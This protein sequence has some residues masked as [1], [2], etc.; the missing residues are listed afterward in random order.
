MLNMNG[1][2]EYEVKSEDRTRF[3]DLESIPFFHH[4][5]KIQNLVK[6]F[7]WGN[8]E[9]EVGSVVL[10]FSRLDG[11]FNVKSNWLPTQRNVLWHVSA[12]IL[13]K[14]FFEELKFNQLRDIWK[15]ET[16]MLSS[17]SQ[18]FSHYAYQSIIGMGNMALPYIFKELI[19]EPDHWFWA[20]SSITGDDPTKEEDGG[21]IQKMTDQWLNWAR[22]RRY[23]D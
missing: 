9:D 21:D 11:S 15:R 4:N 3:D 2:Y 1:V 6:I 23:I 14:D 12:P 13:F 8:K 20:L 18:I 7:S 10:H 17:L 19:S 22:I 16:S 5:S